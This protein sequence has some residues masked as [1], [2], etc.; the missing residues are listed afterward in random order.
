MLAA[1]MLAAATQ[2]PRSYQSEFLAE[3]NFNRKISA[4]N[5]LG[6]GGPI[7]LWAVGH[8][9]FFYAQLVGPSW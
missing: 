2:R 5:F 3:I 4:D 1:A 6:A 8:L 9:L 7:S